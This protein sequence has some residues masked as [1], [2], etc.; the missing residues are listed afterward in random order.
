MFPQ[1]RI[2]GPIVGTSNFTC[3][4][5]VASN[6]ELSHPISVCESRRLSF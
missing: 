3:I 5:V 2:C 1:V 6:E 4:L